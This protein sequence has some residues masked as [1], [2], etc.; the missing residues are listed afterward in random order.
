MKKFI[1]ISFF[2]LITGVASF[3]QT[4]KTPVRPTPKQTAVIPVA[5]TSE[6]SETEWNELTKALESENWDKSTLLSSLALQKLKTDNDK[7]QLANLRYFYLY[8]LAGKVQQ[9][10]TTYAEFEKISQ[11][12]IGKDFLMPSKEVLADCTGK[13]NYICPVKN[14]AMSVRVTA[15]TKASAATSIIFFEYYL[16]DE[17]FDFSKYNAKKGFLS[18]KLTRI[19]SNLKNNIRLIRLFFEESKVEIVK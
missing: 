15:T 13:V 11:A 14:D 1:I 12:F 19:E 3:S 8:S 16:L 5:V 2:L 17:S 10:K 4:K 6:I 9:N 18:G 7:K